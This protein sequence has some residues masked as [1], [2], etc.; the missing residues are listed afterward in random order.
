MDQGWLAQPVWSEDIGLSG[1]MWSE[2]LLSV[3]IR[4]V[5]LESEKAVCA[6]EKVW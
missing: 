3:E 5:G 1:F 2:A 4:Y 6:G